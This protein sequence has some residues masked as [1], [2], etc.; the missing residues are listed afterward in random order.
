VAI[1]AN[2]KYITF[3]C[4][5]T[6]I[7]FEMARTITEIFG[8]RLPAD[9]QRAFISLAAAYRF[10]EALGDWKPYRQVVKDATRRAARF[11]GIEYHDPDGDR[12]YE[13]IG[14]WGPHPDVPEALRTL[15]THYPLV[16][17][18]NAADDQI[19][20]N[21]ARL[22]APFHRVLTAEQARAY[23]PRLAA[24]EFMFDALGAKPEELIHVSSN[25]E[26][27]LRPAAVLG[28]GTRIL[29]DRGLEP[30]QPSLGYH[31]VQDL[32]GLP[33]LLGIAPRTARA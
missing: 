24:F 7:N 30:Q 27:D 8:A 5:G 1:G 28:I 25:P 11:A 17:L 22:G 4:Y 19:P 23:K 16:I 33:E 31:V 2:A 10:D 9:R 13:A 6:L 12:L 15:A 21:V 18:S 32:S 20:A 3:D 29:V 14:T 26:Y